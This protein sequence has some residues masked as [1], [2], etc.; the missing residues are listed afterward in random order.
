VA[1]ALGCD[2][3][4]KRGTDLGCIQPDA[5]RQDR[6]SNSVIHALMYLSHREQTPVASPQEIL[7]AQVNMSG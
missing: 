5:H 4:G 7:V 3:P 6:V 2:K 1:S